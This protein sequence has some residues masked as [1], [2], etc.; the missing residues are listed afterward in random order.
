MISPSSVYL[1]DYSKLY[2]GTNQ[3]YGYETPFLGF[4]TDT[5]ELVF[6]ADKSTYFHFPRTATQV[7]L[8]ATDL[9]QS[10]AFAGSI[11]YKAD[12]IFKKQADYER[13]TPWG[14]A[15]PENLQKGVWLCAWLSGNDTD[16][17]IPPIW[18]DRWYEPGYLDST[19]ALFTS[20]TSAVYDI[21]SSLS[22]DPGC[23]YRYDHTGTDTNL[24]IVNKIK[25]LVIHLDDWNEVTIDQSG[26]KNNASLVNF[27]T[28]MLG[29]S[30]NIPE[31]PND[32]SVLFDGSR[33]YGEVLYSD[34]FDV[35]GNITCNAWVKSSNWRTPQT[36]HF[37]SNGFRGGWH[38]GINTGYF[39]PLTVMLDIDGN[40]AFMNQNGIIFNNIKLPGTSS[41]VSINIDSELYT[42]ILDNGLWNSNKHLYRIDFNGNIDTSVEFSSGVQLLD[43]VIDS[44]NDIWVL[45]NT[46]TL[47]CFDMHGEFKQAIPYPPFRNK[48]TINK[49]DVILSHDALDACVMDNNVYWTVNNYGDLYTNSN[50]FLSGLGVTNIQCPNGNDLYALY[51]YNKIMLIKGGWDD[52]NNVST[53]SVSITSQLPDTAAT[54]IPGRNLSF[55][56]EYENGKYIDYI[57]ITQPSTGY[58]YKYTRDLKLIEKHNITYIKNSLYGSAVK[59]DYSGYNWNRLFNYPKLESP[60]IPQIEGVVYIGTGSPIITAQKIKTTIPV[61]EL[62]VDGWH[63]FTFIID[64]ITNTASIYADMVLKDTKSLP[65]SGGIL[66]KYETPLTLGANTGHI[67]PLDMEIGKIDKLYYS[68]NIDDMRVYTNILSNTDIRHLYLTKFNFKDLIWNMPTGLQSYVE[69][70]TKFFKFKMP[71]QKS[72]FYNIRLIGLNITD[73]TTRE[74]IED[75]IKDVIKKVSPLYTS[76]YKIIW[77]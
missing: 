13:D 26:N 44:N 77:E 42:W 27:D 64:N 3:E 28:N 70:I 5:V 16:T 39:T 75:I 15:L 67:L 38:L 66:Y 53:F 59:G 54:G 57:W 55:T 10:G 36:N 51:D 17:T 61:S 23:W 62:S 48:L 35:S 63:M 41:P 2:T 1:R 24:R 65:A 8:S 34:T 52:I 37:I 7:Q 68:G 45:S 6:K 71:G 31:R 46:Y 47:S 19:H 9:I 43:S 58:V 73:L 49:F 25:N 20:S 72:Q 29:S 21:P 76:L 40:T 60:G 11:P 18:I 56:N 74:I 4:T 32:V 30:V 12:R 50:L 22:F 33:K 69:E 14:N